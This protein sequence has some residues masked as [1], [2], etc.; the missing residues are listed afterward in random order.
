MRVDELER[1]GEVVEA[2]LRKAQP[3]I[4]HV[5]FDVTP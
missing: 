3:T 4:R 2:D 1:I 5:V